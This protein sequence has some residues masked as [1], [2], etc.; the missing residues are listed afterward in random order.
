[1]KDDHGAVASSVDVCSHVG[2]DLMRDG[3]NAA[4]AVSSVP[5][6]SSRRIAKLTSF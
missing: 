4:D 5:A 3:G 6:A 2:V 1:M